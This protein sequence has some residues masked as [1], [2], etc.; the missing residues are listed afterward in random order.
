MAAG[1]LLGLVLR[2]RCFSGSAN[3]GSR[4]RGCVLRFGAELWA[5]VVAFYAAGLAAGGRDNGAPGVRAYCHPS[6][7]GAF[8]LDPDGKNIEA[9]CHRGE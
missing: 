9:V 1:R 5:E 7:Y 3:V 4:F 2:V 8:V 6:Y